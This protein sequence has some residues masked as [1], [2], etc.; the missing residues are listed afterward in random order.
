MT[1][2]STVPYPLFLITGFIL[3]SL[4]VAALATL[5]RGDFVYTRTVAYPHSVALFAVAEFATCRTGRVNGRAVACPGRQIHT[6]HDGSRA[7]VKPS[8]EKCLLDGHRRTLQ[9]RL[10]V[11]V[12]FCICIWACVNHQPRTTI[13]LLS[14]RC[15]FCLFLFGR[16]F[17]L[18][19]L[20]LAAVRL[21]TPLLF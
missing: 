3:S 2:D 16:F 15:F 1:D 12:M 11:S 9:R 8:S 20:F 5:R 19:P 14:R 7:K 10:H 21:R 18:A 17:L 4:E 6:R 13:L